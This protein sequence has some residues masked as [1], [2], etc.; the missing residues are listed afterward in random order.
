MAFIGQPNQQT[1][2][3]DIERNLKLTH[4][5]FPCLHGL[6]TPLSP[7]RESLYRSSSTP[8]ENPPA[9]YIVAL[10]DHADC[11]LAATR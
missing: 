8:W 4:R 5:R 11:Y 6:C 2:W 1:S 7:L 10:G 9:C 3:I